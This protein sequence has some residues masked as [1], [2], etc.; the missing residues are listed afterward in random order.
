MIVKKDD[1]EFDWIELKKSSIPNSG[2]GIYALRNF[3]VD[4]VVTV[5]LGDVVEDGQR[6]DYAFGVKMEDPNG[7]REMD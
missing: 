6:L 1:V 7:W 2:F 5:Y 3:E 4:E